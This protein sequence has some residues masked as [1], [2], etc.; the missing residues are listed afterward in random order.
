MNVRVKH[1]FRISG[2]VFLVHNPEND[3]ITFKVTDNKTM[4]DI[5]EFQYKLSLL[6]E[7]P[8]MM[9]DGQPFQLRQSGAECK[10]ILSMKLSVIVLH[11]VSILFPISLFRF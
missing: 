8:N 4:K 9:V 11:T 10:I 5:G 3:V 6:M 2:L 7:K 1:V